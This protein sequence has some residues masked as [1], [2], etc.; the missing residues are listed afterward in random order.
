M[1]QGLKCQKKTLKCLVENMG[2]WDAKRHLGIKGE[3]N[4]WL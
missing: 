4:F 1:D 2:K 3:W